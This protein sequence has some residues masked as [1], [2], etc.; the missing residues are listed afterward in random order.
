MQEIEIIKNAGIVGAGGAGFPTHV[1]L[2]SQVE[3]LIIN[4]AE[5][6]PLINVDKQLVEFYFDKVYEG[7]KI[8][9]GLIKAKKVVLALK[10]KY[11][12]ALSIAESFKQQEVKF[13]VFKLGDFYPAGDEQVL[14]YEV[15]G[16]IVP[17]GGIPLQVG[18]VVINVETLLNIYKAASGENVTSKYVTV[19]GE[20]KNPLT[21][22]V[23]VGT[24]VKQLIE[25]CGGASVS[26]YACLDGGPMMGKLVD[27]DTYAVKKT[28]KSITTSKLQKKLLR[29]C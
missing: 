14:V 13:E 3:T 9:A 2:S 27:P 1:K 10:E 11:E 15:T 28:T 26:E 6:E 25:F 18:V 29:Y 7:I 8:T 16:K 12:K 4:G 19:N 23:P 22:M 24:P 20:V 5:C 17:E 21:L